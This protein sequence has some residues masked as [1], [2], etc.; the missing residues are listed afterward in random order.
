MQ[1]RLQRGAQPKSQ[2]V[3]LERSLWPR[4]GSALL[5]FCFPLNRSPPKFQPLEPHKDAVGNRRTGRSK[6]QKNGINLVPITEKPQ[7]L[8]L[9]SMKIDF[10][11]RP[12]RCQQCRRAS[13]PGGGGRCNTSVRR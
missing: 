7:Q 12:K 4:T 9:G 1:S 2:D 3:A 5:E 11:Y 8:K 13:E 6:A 10:Q